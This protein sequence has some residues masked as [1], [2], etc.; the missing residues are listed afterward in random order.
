VS[1][2]DGPATKAARSSQRDDDDA[3]AAVVVLTLLTGHSSD[4][5]EP[6]APTAWGDPAHR[7][8]LLPAPSA[9]AWWSSGLPR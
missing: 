6:A 3:A 5:P 9:T 2:N 1:V 4:A 8:R 7:L